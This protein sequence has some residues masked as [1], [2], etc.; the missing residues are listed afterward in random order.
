MTELKDWITELKK[1]KPELNDFLAK[2]DGFISDTG[3][4]GAKFE[5]RVMAGLQNKEEEVKQT[6]IT[7]VEN[8]KDNN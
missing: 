2:L 8:K 1:E 5:K 4:D 7:N 3:F 6:F